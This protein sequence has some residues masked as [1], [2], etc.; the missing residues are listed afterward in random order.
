MFLISE[1][2]ICFFVLHMFFF[3]LLCVLQCTSLEAKLCQM[4][5]KYL[6]LLQEMKS[7][8]WSSSEQTHSG[9]VINRLLEDA[10]QV[11]SAD[12]QEHPILKPNAV[13]YYVAKNCIF[14]SFICTDPQCIPPY[15]NLDYL[16]KF[17]CKN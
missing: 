8:I 14:L 16:C 15:C 6:V 2:Y 1:E 17:S 5:S 3:P 10:L 11:E 12:Q 7:P 4:E 9:E 13:R